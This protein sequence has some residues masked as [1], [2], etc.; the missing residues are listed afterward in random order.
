LREE[1]GGLPQSWILMDKV[2]E[3]LIEMLIS[4]DPKKLAH[5]HLCKDPMYIIYDKKL[6]RY[7]YQCELEM[8]IDGIA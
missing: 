8:R 5:C 7:C 1:I 6:R 3:E 2:D 4:V